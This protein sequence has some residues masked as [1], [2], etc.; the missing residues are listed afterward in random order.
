MGGA[1][2]ERPPF[3][4]GVNGIVALGGPGPAGPGYC[5]A[6]LRGED[7]IGALTG[8]RSPRQSV[9]N[10]AGRPASRGRGGRAGRAGRPPVPRPAAESTLADAVG[11]S[12][13]LYRCKPSRVRPPS[14]PSAGR[15]GGVA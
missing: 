7:I 5:R 9:E 6:P 12:K 4:G 10:P 3:G 11:P 2:E 1:P 8:L 15:P 14:R 13:P